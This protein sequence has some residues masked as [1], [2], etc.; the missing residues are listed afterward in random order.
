MPSPKIVLASNSPRRQELLR[1][2]G[3]EFRLSV[4]EVEE[5]FPDEIPVR[6]VPA[7]LSEKK[8]NAAAEFMKFDE[9]IIAA[10]TVVLFE[11]KIFG[12]PTDADDAKQM[13][14]MLSGEMHEVISGVTLKSREKQ[15]TFSELTRVYFRKLTSEM[16]DYY[17]NKF[18]PLDKAGSYGIQDW[19]GY[20]GIEKVNGC[21]YNVMGLPV[22][23]LV[24]ELG[25]FGFELIEANKIDS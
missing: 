25:A 14:Q 21:F 8:A 19:I 13:L 2:L 11:N 15:I 9:L 22:S 5:T 20:V 17:V 24:K 7:Y 10:D 3:I 1:N 16:I 4:P 12:K 18:Q 6:M 23:R